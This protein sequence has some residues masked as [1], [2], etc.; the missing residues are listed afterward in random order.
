MI[1]DDQNA[2]SDRDQRAVPALA[3]RQ[4][5]V[6]RGEV[7]F[8]RVRCR[9]GRLHQRIAEVDAAFGRSSAAPLTR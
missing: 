8:F 2:R 6:L 7:S 5:F 3:F 4:A 9:P 1:D